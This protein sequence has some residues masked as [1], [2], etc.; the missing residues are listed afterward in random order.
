MPKDTFVK[1][2]AWDAKYRISHRVIK[3]FNV[4]N[5]FFGGDAA[6]VHSPFGGRGMNLGIEDAYVFTQLLIQ[7]RLNEYND[8][9]SKAVAP[10]VKRIF[11]LTNFVTGKTIVS[12]IFRFFAR[13]IVPVMLPFVKKNMLTFVCGMDHEL[14]I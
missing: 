6:H 1:E 10:T 14:Y 12:R 4:G 11:F 5:I 2:V 13:I 9:R 8:A 3:K 7:N